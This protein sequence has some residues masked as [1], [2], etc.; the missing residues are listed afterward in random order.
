M[1][2][3]TQTDAARQLG[4]SAGGRSQRLRGEKETR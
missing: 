4:A 3:R 1:A 2:K